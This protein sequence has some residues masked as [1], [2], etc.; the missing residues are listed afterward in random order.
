MHPSGKKA[1][2]RFANK[3]TI[4]V[5]KMVEINSD[6]PFTVSMWIRSPDIVKG[7]NMIEIGDKKHA[8]RVKLNYQG[9][10]SAELVTP[11]G[12]ISTLVAG[13]MA[14]KPRSWQHLAVSY[15]GGRSNSS[16][17]I[18]HDGEV[19]DVRQAREQYLK[20]GTFQGKVYLGKD[21]NTGGISHV[22][23]YNRLLSVNELKL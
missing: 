22:R 18:I 14:V 10:I 12:K 13:D 8:L 20:D 19:K 7:A 4:S 2:V 15:S 9:G 1:G 11:G 5:D 3:G 6:H 23:F 16:I 17:R 21:F